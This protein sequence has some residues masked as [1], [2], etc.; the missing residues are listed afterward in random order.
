MTEETHGN[1]K[2]ACPASVFEG[3]RRGGG[4]EP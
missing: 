4:P 2:T 3:E 1:G